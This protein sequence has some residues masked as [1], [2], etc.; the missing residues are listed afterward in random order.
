MSC[1]VCH[2]RNKFHC[3]FVCSVASRVVETADQRQFDF[4]KGYKIQ[5]EQQTSPQQHT[6][7]PVFPSDILSRVFS[8]AN[9]YTRREEKQQSEKRKKGRKR[10]FCD[11][12]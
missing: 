5:V 10:V 6:I 3:D 8:L 9:Q 7:S 1:K 4:E 12:K 11:F 2:F